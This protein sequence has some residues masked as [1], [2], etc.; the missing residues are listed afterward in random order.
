MS[1]FFPPLVLVVACAS[2]EPVGG[3][4]PEDY[5]P[6]DPVRVVFTGDSITDLET[7]AESAEP[8]R[9][10]PEL[11]WDNDDAM[12]PEA[13]D[14]TLPARFPG[15][16][17]SH[18][19]AQGGSTS[20]DL[21]E[22]LADLLADLPDRSGETLVLVTTGGNDVNDAPKT[23]GL[24]RR[25]G[26]N[27]VEHVLALRDELDAVFEDPVRLYVTNVYD[28]T[29]RGNAGGGCFPGSLSPILDEVVAAMNLELLDGAETHG[30]AVVDLHGHFYEHGYGEVGLDDEDTLNAD[31]DPPHWFADCVH[32]NAR[33]HHELRGL[34]LD[35][36][37]R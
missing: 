11:L 33:G 31:T 7:A 32:P 19:V 2:P 8:Y 6:T 37:S 4:V 25:S 34:F 10:Y 16:T 22:Q 21:A 23:P 24:G 3:F 26:R 29:G 35:A 17:A 20:A 9:M 13:A 5:Q 15:L 1:R 30:F 27:M 28:P 12:W 36:V 18:N 14:A